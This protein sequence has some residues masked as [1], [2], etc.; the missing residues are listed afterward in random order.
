MAACCDGSNFADVAR[1][2]AATATSTG[3]RREHRAKGRQH[4]VETGVVEGQFLRVG[5]L[6]LHV[7]A[8]GL[9]AAAA[10]FEQGRHAVGRDDISKAARRVRRGVAAADGDVQQALAGAHIGGLGERLADDLQGG[11]DDPEVAASPG[12]LPALLDHGEIERGVELEPLAETLYR[13]LME[14]LQQQGLHVAPIEVYLRCRK[15]LSM[16]LGVNPAPK[17]EALYRKAVAAARE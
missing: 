16:V 15:M 10:L 7:Q 17:T 2:A 9:R 14:C 8:F 4:D 6:E 11:A 13:R 3:F 5:N 12:G 1:W